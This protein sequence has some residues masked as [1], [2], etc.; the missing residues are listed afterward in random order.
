MSSMLSAIVYSRTTV[1]YAVMAE[2][3]GRFGHIGSEVMNC[4]APDTGNMGKA[5][6]FLAAICR[7]RLM[8]LYLLLLSRGSGPLWQRRAAKEVADST[9]EWRDSFCVRDDGKIRCVLDHRSKETSAN[10]APTC[11]SHLPML[12]TFARLLGRK[13]KT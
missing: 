4:S 8:P 7:V 5:S 11:K 9:A 2:I 13:G 3:M 12:R 1:Q 10:L 6:C